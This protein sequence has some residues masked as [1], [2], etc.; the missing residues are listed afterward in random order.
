MTNE[1][2]DIGVFE[3]GSLKAYIATDPDEILASQKLRYRVFVDEMGAKP[4]PEML[5]SKSDFDKYDEVC[6]HLLVVDSAKGD[7]VVGSYRILRRSRLKDGMN[8]YTQSEFDLSKPLAHF[9]GEVMELGRSCVDPNY[10]DRATM[11]LLWRALGEYQSKYDIEL[12]FGCAS[13]NGS[14]HQDHAASLTYLYKN[15]LAPENLRPRALDKL[16]TPMDLVELE[17]SQIKRVV[18]AMPPLVKGYLR[19]GAYIGDGAFEDHDYNTTDVCII[20][21][22][23]N[24]SAKYL[25]KFGSKNAEE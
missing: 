2:A 5:E 19:L 15:H 4:S 12:M 3:A 20:F 10:R 22:L 21:D 23:K 18:A 7:E 6:D 1:S 9:K 24:V 17:D 11:G 14:N 8:F 13:F 16:Y 25:E